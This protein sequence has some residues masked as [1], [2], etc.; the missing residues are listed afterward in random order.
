MNIAIFGGSFDPPHIGHEQ[1]ATLA[2]KELEIDKLFIVPTYLNPFKNDSFL[3]APTRLE[4][5]ND[6]FLD[7]KKVEVL[8][9]EVNKKE[10]VPTF[11]TVEYLKSLYDIDKIYL[12]IGADNLKSIHLWYNAKKLKE[13]VEFIVIS[14][15]QH[16]IKNDYIDVQTLHLDIDISSSKLRENMELEYIPKKIQQKVRKFWKIE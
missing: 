3:D 9:Y 5:I 16:S 4:L 6:M 14:R 2:I 10:K 8:A 7:I 13:L 1:I 15:E 12:I 11:K